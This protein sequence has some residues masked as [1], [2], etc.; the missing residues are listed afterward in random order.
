MPR[1]GWR[2][3]SGRK[4]W[5]P[6]Q[7]EA[8][9]A[10]NAARRDATKPH[11]NAADTAVV[12]TA[13]AK[14]KQPWF[15]GQAELILEILQRSQDSARKKPRTMDWNPFQPLTRLHKD[16]FPPAA[17]PKNKK[18]HL[19]MDETLNTT[20]TWAAQSWMAGGIFSN[21]ASEGLLFLGYPYLSQL[22]QR[23]E[24]RLFGEIRAEEMT[25]KWIKY[26]GTDDES[27][28]EKGK[29]PKKPPG[30]EDFAPSQ[31]NVE[32]DPRDNPDKAK[33]RSDS[34]NKEIET[35]IKELEDY[36][37][38]LKLRDW[39]KAAAAQDS[40]FGISHLLLDLKDADN[41][42]RNN[43]ALR[44][45][46][47]NGRDEISKVKL[48]KGCLKGIRTIEP[49]WCY[50]TTY[51]ASN[52][53]IPTWY[54]PQVWYVMGTEIHKTRILSFIG[55]PVPDILKPAYAFGGL[56]MTQMAQPYVDIWLR[57]RESVGEII[58]AFSVMVL[59]TNLATTTM[60][61]GAGGGPG[62]VLARVNLFNQLRD[63][64][65][66][67]VIDKDTEDFMNV[68]API[69]GLSDL[70][71]QAQE[72]LCS[73]ARYPAVKFTGI[74]P[75]GFNACL[76]ADTLIETDQGQVPI[77]DVHIGQKVM[78]RKG[79]APIEKV[80]CTGYA[81]ELIE[82]ET[83]DSIIRC[84]ANHQIWLPSINAFVPA[85]NVR[86]GDLLLSR[87]AIESL[88]TAH[89]SHGEAVFGGTGEMATT[90]PRYSP[91]GTPFS[92]ERSGAFTMGLFRKATTFITSTRIARTISLIISQCLQPQSMRG[93]TVFPMGSLFL[94]Q[95]NMN[96]S[97]ATAVIG[98]SCQN[99]RELC[100]AVG[101]AGSPNGGEISHRKPSRVRS[102]FALCAAHLS[103]RSE[104]T[105]NFVRE[106]AQ[107]RARIAPRICPFITKNTVKNGPN[108][109]NVETY[110]GV[111]SVR[112]VPAQE[113]VY[114]IQ[115]AHG[116]LP[117]FF[118]NGICVHN[119]S[120]GELRA[121]YDTI[122]GEQQHLYG[123]HLTSVTDIMQISLWG[124]RDPDIIHEFV[125]LWELTE[126]EKSEKRKADM[127][128]D[129]G[130]L[131]SGV[132][133]PEEI[134]TKVA[135]DPESG[136]DSI[137]PDDVP[138]LLDEEIQGLEPVGGR[139]QPQAGEKEPGKKA[140]AAEDDDPTATEA[141]RQA[142]VTAGGEVDDK[143]GRKRR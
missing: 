3:N 105:R 52:P 20:N 142:I 135:N 96:A 80:G 27:T 6:E 7:K 58:H 114:D 24:F 143:R 19:A 82:I 21:V 87:G 67:F 106:D 41:E 8:A 95:P 33:G 74:Q 139:P 1:G 13:A 115:V 79:W 84:T 140:A 99:R 98:L 102:A 103:K 72:H 101:G 29:K 66:A 48:E 123:P 17:L 44:H 30:A 104:R 59:K 91:A 2:P 47:G 131:D 137:D 55:R 138:D 88:S 132:L 61:G 70:Q 71:A 46:I 92:I 125:P 40:F 73:V 43:P 107:A 112:R 37:K 83:A 28:K 94:D 5:T 120:E 134:R 118:A 50:P 22:A 15:G 9:R 108:T 49:I 54:D 121:F 129:V 81:T 64:Q 86:R 51:N 26:R 42:D 78:T 32:L 10:R 76:T 75:K 38:D 77:R 18:L 116:F 16:C 85:E 127:E 97:A 62:D 69:S 14:P 90:P 60:P 124:Q 35:K 133:S 117:E 11:A 136:Y 110:C 23:P 109:P 31:Q 36:A 12:A 126:K 65:G 111:S 130:Y 100:F 39:F 113:F 63:N 45:S 93:F 34:R 119:S 68:A 141:R 122:N 53:L 57:T 56:A 4:P 25:R 128:V 89:Q